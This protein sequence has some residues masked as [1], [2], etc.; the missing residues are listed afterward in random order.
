[1]ANTRNVYDTVVRRVLQWAYGREP[2]SDERRKYERER[3]IFWGLCQYLKV[4]FFKDL[5][6][7]YWWN[8]CDEKLVH[9]CDGG[10][11]FLPIPLDTN[12]T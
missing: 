5:A 8:S 7:G 9:S 6:Q 3:R 2:P 12:S 10:V 1:M 4:R 11:P